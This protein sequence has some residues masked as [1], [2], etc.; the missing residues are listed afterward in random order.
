[1]LPP[2]AYDN[3]INIGVDEIS[4]K[5]GYKYITIIYDL[6]DGKAKP[7]DYYQG[8]TKQSL[9][10]FFQKLTKKQKATIKTV[11]TDMS[12]AYIAS[13][14]EQLPKADI[15]IDKFHLENLLNQAID[16]IRKTII[17]GMA[18]NTNKYIMEKKY[19]GTL[20]DNP[21]GNRKKTEAN[22]SIN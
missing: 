14:K 3:L 19:K 9:K 6:S 4:F 8:N 20:T 18:D 17:S 12:R 13:I 11:N 1:M 2:A 10:A 15:I 21:K 16:S 7:I 22:R 5:K